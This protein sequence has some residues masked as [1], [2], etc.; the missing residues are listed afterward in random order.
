M[1]VPFGKRP[2]TCYSSRGT[3]YTRWVAHGMPALGKYEWV[4]QIVFFL[5]HSEKDAKAGTKAGG[6]GFLMAMPSARW[7]KNLLHIHGVTNWHNVCQVGAHVIRINRSDGPPDTFNFECHEW[8]FSRGGPDI[9]ISPPLNLSSPPHLVAVMGF[10]T[11]LTRA[12]ETKNE[13]GPADDVFMVGR[14]IDYDGME[15]NEPSFRFGHISIAD[16][17]VQQPTFYRGRSLVVDMHSRA[18]FSGSPVFVYRTPGSGFP[19]PGEMYFGHMMK[20][21]GMH[22]GQFP[23]LWELKDGRDKPGV[24]SPESAS[25]ITTGRYVEGLSGMTCVIPAQDILD[26]FL[27]NPELKAMRD[28]REEQAARQLSD[29]GKGPKAEGVLPDQ[30]PAPPVDDGGSNHRARFTALLTAAAKKRPQDERT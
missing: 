11:L 14:F 25:L 20:C 9:A 7:G 10:E 21:L 19:E 12:D 23:E 30:Q 22:W 28:A 5:Y 26:M 15:T 17:T 18:G 4:K 2:V 8:V 29:L 27:N 3:P 1:D 13:I 24:K 6:T 16:A